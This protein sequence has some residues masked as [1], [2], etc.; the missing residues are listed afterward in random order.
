MGTIVKDLWELPKIEALA[1]KIT[2][3]GIDVSAYGERSDKPAYRITTEGDS[4]EV[5]SANELINAILDMGRKGATIQRYKG[6]GEMN[7]E[8]LWETTMNPEGRKLLQV[9]LEDVVEVERVFTTLMGESVEL[10]RAFIQAHAL[11][12]RNLDI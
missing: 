8:Q 6:L 9:K 11:E 3:A 4:I 10:R 7:P 1:K 5:R 12:V 2:A